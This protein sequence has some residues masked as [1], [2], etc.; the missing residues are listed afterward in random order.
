MA[1]LYS[2]DRDERRRASEAVSEA[3]E[4]PG[5]RTPDVRVRARS[6]STTSPSTTACAATRPGSS[7]RNLG[8]ATSDE[9]GAGAR[10]T[11]ASG[12]R[13]RATVPSRPSSSMSSSSRFLRPDG[14]DRRRPDEGVV[15]RAREIVLGAYNDFMTEA[16]DVAGRFFAESWIDAPSGEQAHRCLLRD[17][18]AGRAPV[19]VDELHR[20]PPLD[21]HPRARAPTVCTAR[22]R[23]RSGCSTP[24][25]R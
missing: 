16:G 3:L 19:R 12:A 1:K 6:S 4:D 10:S 24:R 25:P 5:L 22:S 23:R 11:P 18:G 9:G 14:A 2:A 20:R 21:P 17:V 15:G 13:R 8:T 7:S